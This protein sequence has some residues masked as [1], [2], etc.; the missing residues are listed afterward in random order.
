[1][2]AILEVTGRQGH[3]AVVEI[4]LISEAV[5]PA[6]ASMEFGC[7]KISVWLLCKKPF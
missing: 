6:F 1:M 2:P 5:L 7:T 4:P 3:T